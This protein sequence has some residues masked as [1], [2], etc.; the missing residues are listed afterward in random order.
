MTTSFLRVR[1][2]VL[3]FALALTGTLAVGAASP[4]AALGAPGVVTVQKLDESGQLLP[5][6][7]FQGITCVTLD[8]TSP[9]HCVPLENYDFWEAMGTEGSVANV[10]D[11]LLLTGVWGE[12]IVHCIGVAEVSPPAGY[13]RDGAPMVVCK[14]PG[15]WTLDNVPDDFSVESAGVTYTKSMG[16]WSVT[17]E[18]VQTPDGTVP[19]TVLSL[20]NARE[21]P[22]TSVRIEKHDE[23]G[24]LLPGAQIKAGLC[25]RLDG[26]SPW[27]CLPLDIFDWW[28][29]LANT[30]SVEVAKDSEGGIRL[31]MP[32]TWGIPTV[33]CL[34]AWE[35]AAPV[36]YVA[37]PDPAMVCL[38]PDGFTTDV[39]PESVDFEGVT[40]S[41]GLNS[42]TVTNDAKTGKTV[43]ALTNT[44]MVL[45]TP[46]LP[47]LEVA[48]G[49]DN[50]TVTPAPLAHT[51][52][53]FSGWSAG[54]GTVT[55]TSTDGYG[56]L[57]DGSLATTTTVEVADAA[58]TCPSSK[59]PQGSTS[60]RDG[61]AIGGAATGI[62]G[63]AA[64]YAGRADAGAPGSAPGAPQIL[65]G[66][67]AAA[68]AVGAG[69]RA[70][71]G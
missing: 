46:A 67:L 41:P 2:T 34:V 12:P 32:S 29:E 49:P 33:Q 36:G 62:D 1:A 40:V 13:V 65:V 50:D 48:C 55:Y 25:N 27:N 57:V 53:T 54:K 8:G 31:L 47:T 43:L 4:A 37:D 63:P 35:E 44:S 30:G 38:G 3:A 20:A 10:F 21:V 56:W 5:G 9:W 71:R 16:N 39:G 15:G 45:P 28:P 60:T 23:T 64:S 11:E 66:L 6:G 14:G 69:L 19:T 7:Q 24:A 18:M 51:T 42:W 17:N 52:A 58:T 59:E 26:T 70:V 61:Y 22:L 68:L